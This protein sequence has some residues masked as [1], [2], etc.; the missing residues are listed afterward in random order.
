MM[1]KLVWRN[2]WRNKRRT[3][4]T[5]TS[6]LFAV[7]FAV[8]L[9]AFHLGSW[10]YLLDSVL[11][12]YSGYVQVHATGYWK[13]KTID[14]AFEYTQALSNQIE[15]IGKKHHLEMH[16]VPRLESFSLASSG[17]K[18]K[19]VMVMGIEPGVE[20]HLMNLKERIIAGKYITSKDQGVLVSRGLASFLGLAIHDTIVLIGQGYHGMSA[21]AKY[22]VVGVVRLPSLEFDNQLIFMP[23][24]LNQNFLS[25]PGMVTSVVINYEHPDRAGNLNKV[26]S[27]L[28]KEL[29]PDVYEVM[30]WKQMMKELYQQF[31]T[32][33]SSGVI[34]LWILYLIVG[35]GIFG[36]I[37]MMISERKYEFGVMIAIGMKKAKVIRMVICEMMI[38]GSLGV[39]S[40]MAIS[41]PVVFYFHFHPLTVSG[42]M[43][44]TLIQYGMEPIIPVAWRTDYIFNQAMAI[45]LMVWLA[46]IY[47]LYSI[48]KLTIVKALKK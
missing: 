34:I 23:L 14:N 11:K 30:T 7:F 44:A 33:D 41:L 35:F 26:A 37:L 46:L 32:D 9:R 12:S 18:T 47:P 10:I 27:I 42:K 38:I 36:T 5:M 6:I 45:F 15:T 17:E 16:A 39:L 29:V 25:A 43:A 2:I 1:F 8:L 22:E 20:S 48:S 3:V 40:G 19:A 13:D 31:Q 21:Y 28:Q 4:I 24:T